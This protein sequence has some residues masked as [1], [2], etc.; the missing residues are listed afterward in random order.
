[1]LIGAITISDKVNKQNFI[2]EA[3]DEIDSKLGFIY[4]LP[5]A[6]A[7]VVTPDG[8]SWME[9]PRHEVLL[10]KTISNRLATGR[11]ILS[12]DTAGEQTQLHA[13]GWY[14]VQEALAELMALANQVVDLTAVKIPLSES[15]QSDMT[16]SVRN[17]DEES[18]L[19]GF[20]NT[21]MRGEPWYSIP[22][23]VS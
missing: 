10:L 18:L 19:L 12:I 4:R 3:A 7:D 2:N 15:G 21:V 20:E 16:A 5:L 22:G 23:Q 14:L 17:H 13:Y 1:M 9:L 11:L 6:P 8:N